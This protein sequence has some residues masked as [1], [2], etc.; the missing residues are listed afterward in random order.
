MGKEFLIDTNVLIYV[1]ANFFPL[2]R[3]KLEEI[4]ENSFNISIVSKVELLCYGKLSETDIENIRE[5]LEE[6]KIHF[7]DD[8]IAEKTIEL[9]KK[10]GLK[11]PDA[12]IAATALVKNFELVTR[13]EKDFEKIT[14]LEI[15]N[16]Y[17]E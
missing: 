16:P 3:E 8:A 13:N 12:F 14:D 10:Y 11:L 9:R 1:L 5:F 15:Y 4:L 6:A 17:K 7:I 2:E